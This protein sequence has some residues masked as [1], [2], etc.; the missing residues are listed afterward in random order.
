MKIIRNA[1]SLNRTRK[2]PIPYENHHILPKAQF[3]L[4]IKKE[5]NLVLLTRE[6]HFEVH[7]HACYIW[8]N[9]RVAFWHMCHS[10]KYGNIRTPEEYALA[11]SQISISTKEKMKDPKIRQLLSQNT[12]EQFKRP[13]FLEFHTSK[14]KEGM[15]RKESW[16][17]FLETVKDTV[18]WTDGK[19]YIRLKKGELPPEGFKRGHQYI[20]HPKKRG[21]QS[22]IPGSIRYVSPDGK[23]HY[24]FSIPDGCVTEKEWIQKTGSPSQKHG[25]ARSVQCVETGETFES[26]AQAGRK[27]PKARSKIAEVCDGKRMRA[28]KLHWK[29]ASNSETNS[30]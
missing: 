6:E 22:I 11:R 26:I 24:G 1:Q 16:S 15:H 29:W 10:K 3:P 14:T 8:P 7:R 28:G 13:G 23:A 30:A 25:R 20:P 12:K 5:S 4:W 18:H 21:Q 19:S 9:Q 2:D 17:S 27:Y